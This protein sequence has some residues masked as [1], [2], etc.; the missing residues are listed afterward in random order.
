MILPIFAGGGVG[1]SLSPTLYMG[2]NQILKSDISFDFEL[3]GAT[4]NPKSD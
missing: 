1:L 4:K 2:F 3:N